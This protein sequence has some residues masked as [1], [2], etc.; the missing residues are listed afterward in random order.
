MFQKH[1]YIECDREID[2]AANEQIDNEYL[3]EAEWNH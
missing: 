3:S 2:R 1:F